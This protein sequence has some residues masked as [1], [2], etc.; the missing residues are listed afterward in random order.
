MI[1][2][3]NFIL[4][5]PILRFHSVLSAHVDA[6][7]ADYSVLAGQTGRNEKSGFDSNSM[8]FTH[9]LE[10]MLA[11]KPFASEQP[12]AIGSQLFVEM[13]LIPARR[14][15]TASSLT[16]ATRGFEKTVFLGCLT[17]S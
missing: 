1:K 8:A 14:D 17:E 12:S 3:R 6:E 9:F 7:L 13:T 11:V 16:R 10:L 5:N 4:C 15:F 2:R